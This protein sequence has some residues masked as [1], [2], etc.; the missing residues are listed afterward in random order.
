[1]FRL[2]KKKEKVNYPKVSIQMKMDKAEDFEL[3]RNFNVLEF[4][5]LKYIEII[6]TNEESMKV[7]YEYFSLPSLPDD[8]I[9]GNY[10]MQVL[11]LPHNESTQEPKVLYENANFE[12]NVSMMEYLTMTDGVGVITNKE[13]K[14]FK[15]DTIT[16]PRKVNGSPVIVLKGPFELGLKQLTI[17]NNVDTVGPFAFANNEIVELKYEARTTP[18]SISARAFFRNKLKKVKVHNK[19]DFIGANAFAENEITFVDF[20]DVELKLVKDAFRGNNIT[21]VHIDK[22]NIKYNANFLGQQSNGWTKGTLKAR[23]EQSEDLSAHVLYHEGQPTG[24]T[25]SVV[26]ENTLS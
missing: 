16:F 21:K 1:M 20:A 4:D 25:V 15:S 23:S 3:D 13:H 18:L 26:D 5:D 2:F 6:L 8:V 22:A 9:T 17:P 7:N 19:I 14:F 24:W 10:D 11:Y 12:Y